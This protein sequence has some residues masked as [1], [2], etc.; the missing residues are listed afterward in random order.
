MDV[1]RGKWRPER[2]KWNALRRRSR[3][4]PTVKESL[5]QNGKRKSAVNSSGLKRRGYKRSAAR[6]ALRRR[7]QL[8][9]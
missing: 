6:S 4:K 8:T 1:L 5:R 2:G 7:K 3:R 9:V